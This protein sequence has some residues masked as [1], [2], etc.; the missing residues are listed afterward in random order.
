[1]KLGEI[2][3]AIRN[4]KKVYWSSRDYEVIERIGEFYIRC[5]SN[6]HFI[7]LTWE[8]GITLNGSEKD[9]FIDGKQMHIV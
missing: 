2:K 5:A 7:G 4:G 3:S 9:F 8:D 1:M 6:N